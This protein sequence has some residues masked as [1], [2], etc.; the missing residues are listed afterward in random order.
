M[1]IIQNIACIPATLYP[2]DKRIYLNNDMLKGK[3]IQSIYLFASTED[4]LIKSPKSDNNISQI[5]EFDNLSLYFNLYDAKGVHFIK[6]FGHKNLTIDV[7]CVYS[8]NN[9]IEYKINRVLDLQK[10]YISYLG[11]QTSP[12]YLLLYVLYQTENF[13][14]FTDEVSGSLSFNIPIKLDYKPVKLSDMTG[15]ALEN[16][17]IKQ[18][19]IKT[20]TEYVLPGY[21]DIY[22]KNKKRLDMI[23]A[24]WFQ[25]RDV[26]NFWLDDLL[27]DFEKSYY[28]QTSGAIANPI[29][30][31]IY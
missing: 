24:V 26:K 1:Q 17:K 29:I 28:H 8:Q 12:L 3:K 27:I 6:D 7:E 15:Y 2:D 23:P 18:I 20:D 31:F 25:I 22:T 21:F 30:T 5:I 14:R 10:S 19:I 4:L 9:Y 13:S 11:T 16:K